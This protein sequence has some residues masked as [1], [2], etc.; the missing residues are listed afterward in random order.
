MILAAGVALIATPE[1]RA[2]TEI[3]PAAVETLRRMTE[4]LGSLDRFSVETDN[5]LED[6]LVSGQKIQYD[7]SGSVLIERPDKLR[8][9]RAGDRVDQLV[10]YDGKTL[11]IHDRIGGY[12]ALAEAPA[13]LDGLLHFA[14]DTLDLVP[15]SGDLIYTNAYELLTGSLTSGFV[16]GKSMIDGVRCDHLAFRNPA[17]DWQIWIAD[18]DE[19]LPRKYV[20]TTRDD[21]AHPQYEIR[22]RRWNIAP[23]PDEAAF[24]FAAPE[25]AREVEFLR[26]DSGRSAGR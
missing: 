4:Y 16:V 20:V 23:A 5:A 21:P 12:Y 14:R 1:A 25:D 18:G 7:F 6:V 2:Q 24:V 10:V 26:L 17:V 3:E 19:P 9:E 22:M 13:E 15:P 8:V 11:A